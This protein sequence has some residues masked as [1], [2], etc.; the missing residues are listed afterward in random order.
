MFRVL[1]FCH[2]LS[3][4]DW[5]EANGFLKDKHKDNESICINLLVR[6]GGGYN[7]TFETNLLDSVTLVL[8]G[9]FSAAIHHD[10]SIM[11]IIHVLTR[12][13]YC[14]SLLKSFINNFFV[15]KKCHFYLN[16]LERILF[17]NKRCIK[18]ESSHKLFK[19]L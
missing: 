2:Y 18:S 4:P 13:K 6:G 19:I 7:W 14:L 5:N 17:W 11:N 12:L 8:S 16:Y 15:W 3:L 1:D 9:H 10:C